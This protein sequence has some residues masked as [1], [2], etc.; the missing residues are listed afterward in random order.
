MSRPCKSQ[1]SL[2]STAY[3]VF[4][5]AESEPNWKCDKARQ[6]RSIVTPLVRSIVKIA[7]ETTATFSAR[8]P[9]LSGDTYSRVE[10]KRSDIR[11]G[12]DWFGRHGQ[13]GQRRRVGVTQAVT[14]LIPFVK[15]LSWSQLGIKSD[16]RHRGEEQMR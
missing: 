14:L 12:S 10:S 7:E 1:Q 8:F 3:L 5:A 15:M 11:N 16:K 6:S 4:F 13:S 2:C 9:G